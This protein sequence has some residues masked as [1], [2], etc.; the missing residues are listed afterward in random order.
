MDPETRATEPRPDSSSGWWDRHLF[1]SWVGANAAAFLI[2]VAGGTLL[3][4]LT[5]D[6]TSRG[7]ST[8]LVLTVVVVALVASAI[9]GLVLGRLQ[10]RV[11][12]RRLPALPRRTWLVAT[13]V[14]AFLAFALVIAPDALDKVVTGSNPFGVFKESLVQVVVL[15]PLIGVAQATALRG[16]TSRWQ[17]WFVGNVTSWLF[18]ALTT[19]AA[20]WLLGHV[21]TY[22]G[23]SASVTLSPAFPVLAIAFH[24]L[25]MLWVTAPEATAA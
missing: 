21:A 14:P 8:H 7:A 16:L 1:W 15:G 6:V 13:A 23:D 19:E 11:L 2:I 17:W 9:Y 5:S 3:L 4:G 20:K 10:W 18:G 25:W 22:P 12:R 24:G